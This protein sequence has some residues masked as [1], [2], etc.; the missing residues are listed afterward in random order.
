MDNKIDLVKKQSEIAIEKNHTFMKD[1]V[2]TYK[3]D[4]NEAKRNYYNAKLK[5]DVKEVKGK[6]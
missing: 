2:N 4:S 6:V 1:F 5:F 3:D